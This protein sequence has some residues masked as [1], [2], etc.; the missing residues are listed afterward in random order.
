MDRHSLMS[1]GELRDKFYKMR[2][3]K[4]PT[5]DQVMEYLHLYSELE[6]RNAL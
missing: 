2:K 6:Y 4:K 1:D 3:W 5:Y